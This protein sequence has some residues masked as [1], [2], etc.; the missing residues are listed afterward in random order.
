MSKLNEYLLVVMDYCSKWVKVSP[1]PQRTF[2]IVDILI[3]ET[4]IHWG[5]LT[6][7]VLD[8]GPQF[9]GATKEVL[10]PEKTAGDD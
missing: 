10:Q 6:Y 9:T 5:T 3:K 2:D 4:F 7:L 8:R 1:L